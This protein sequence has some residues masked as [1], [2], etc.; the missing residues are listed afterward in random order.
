MRIAC[1]RGKIAAIAGALVVVS[2][3]DDA[4]DDSGAATT[5]TSSGAVTTSATSP[6]SSSG[7][8]GADGEGAS[9]SGG[10]GS[11]SVGSGGGTAAAG[12]GGSG[13]G[14]AGGAPPALRECG[15]SATI[16][17]AW[18]ATELGGL[19]ELTGD[20][21]S[22]QFVE[23]P[24]FIH[25]ATATNAKYAFD[26]REEEEP[27]DLRA[28]LV[29]VEVTDLVS[30]DGYGGAVVTA[31]APGLSLFVSNVRLE[32]NWPDWV[33]YDTTNYD[34]M[35]LDDSEELYAEDL[36]VLN[37][38]A[39]A[40]LDIKT[41]HAELV[42]L[43]T[44]GSG[45]RALRFWRPGP[46]YLVKSTIENDTQA[47]VWMSDCDATTLYVYDSTFNGEP[48]IPEG[49][50]ECENGADPSVVYLDVDPRTTGEMHPMFSTP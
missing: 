3:G 9:S 49:K 2:C 18:I 34:G 39:D 10:G 17:N 43:R 23:V 12:G 11:A 41:N 35:V 29:D 44:G 16:P 42:C 30:P 1:D 20:F 13:S 46:H 32:P 48:T 33:S 25:D 5:G 21:T 15:D 38:N 28:A 26:L 22:R 45:H 14:G 47:L 31:N 24:R 27:V 19:P 37:W 7:S 50:L 8:G 40:A 4:V 6:S 36:T